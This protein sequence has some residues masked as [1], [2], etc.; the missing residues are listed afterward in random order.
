MKNPISKTN[1]V[2]AAAI[3]GLLL[4]FP[5]SADKPSWAGSGKDEER[6]EG[7]KSK[8][9]HE[10]SRDRERHEERKS[11]QRH[12]GESRQRG[13]V[14]VNIQIGSYFDDRRR[15]AVHDYYHEQFRSGHCP[16]GLAKKRNGC[17]P[18]GQARK[19]HVG[20]PLPQG[21]EY[22]DVPAEVVVKIGQPPAGHRYVQVA[23]DILLIAV[24]TGMIV[25][26]I[27]DLGRR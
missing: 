7:K 24:G 26:A 19:W 23:A 11:K 17:M 3:A 1:C 9:R 13:S 20:K 25:D 14:E 6:H 22:H 12:E 15:E 21:V 27:E 8:Q 18:P 16:P 4:S 2:L 10:E 5:A